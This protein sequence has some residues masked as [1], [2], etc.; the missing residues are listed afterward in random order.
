MNNFNQKVIENLL[1]EINKRK[2]QKNNFIYLFEN[3]QIKSENFN[4]FVA[5]AKNYNEL[6][7]KWEKS[8]LYERNLIFKNINQLNEAS[9]SDLM[10]IAKKGYDK[11]KGFITNQ[12]QNAWNKINDFIVKIFIQSISLAGKGKGA[13]ARIFSILNKALSP[14][15][16][17]CGEHKT[18]CKIVSSFVII[19][20]V[21]GVFAVMADNARAEIEVG[22]P[23]PGGGTE[24]IPLDKETYQVARALIQKNT[25]DPQMAD[26][27]MSFL[28]QA[29]NGDFKVMMD[30]T[31]ESKAPVEEALSQARELMDKNPE[32]FNKLRVIGEKLQSSY[33]NSMKEWASELFKLENFRK[34]LQKDFQKQGLY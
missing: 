30:I 3:N 31:K 8:I 4:N 16:K 5:R 17:F 15:F 22:L 19:L 2:F 11:T 34:G 9:F 32:E 26:S 28:D 20:V 13:F 10:I 27:I 18:F 23:R 33:M 29:Q 24:F 7:N 12:A 14:I 25:S 1:N 21:S 6:L